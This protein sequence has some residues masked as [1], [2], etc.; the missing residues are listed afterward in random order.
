MKLSEQI[1]D[2]LEFTH[3][4]IIQKVESETNLNSFEAIIEV[5]TNHNNH[6][7]KLFHSK[8][9]RTATNCWNFECTRNGLIQ[10][11]YVD[12]TTFN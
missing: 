6:E 12:S 3:Q 5:R 2:M 7:H 4:D 10:K 8:V 1:K 9:T 11:V